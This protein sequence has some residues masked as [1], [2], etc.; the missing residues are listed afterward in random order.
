VQIDF[1]VR[2]AE[3]RQLLEI[4]PADTHDNEVVDDTFVGGGRYGIAGDS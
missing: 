3:A 2:R 4:F 1:E